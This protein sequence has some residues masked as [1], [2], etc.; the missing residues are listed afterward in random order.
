MPTS[1]RHL[2]AT[3]LILCNP[4]H[5]KLLWNKFK[6]YMT[7]DYVHENKPPNVAELQALEDI[8]SILE[9]LGK[10]INDYEIVSFNVN[11]DE[12]E[13]L[14]RMIA[15]ETT[16]LDIQGDYACAA[17]LN[18]QQ[19]I[20]YDTIMEKVNSNSSAVYFIDGP[21]GTCKTFLFKAL[22]VGV[23]SQNLIALATVSSGVSVSLLPGG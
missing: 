6:S 22:L 21:G 1:L 14:T 19:K 13:R 12:N 7:D 2:F 9:S 15:E 17:S 10:N 3:L 23:R 18:N 11:I 5:P 16:N 8:S 20:A 4:D